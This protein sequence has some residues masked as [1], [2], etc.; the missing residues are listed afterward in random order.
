M[1]TRKPDPV[2]LMLMGKMEEATQ[3]YLD[4]YLEALESGDHFISSELI[5]Q[6]HFSVAGH[7]PGREPESVSEEVKRLVMTALSKGGIDVDKQV[8]IDDLAIA[9]K[10]LSYDRKQS[11]KS[12]GDGQREESAME[13]RL[14]A[15]P[16]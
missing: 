7:I 8:V 13:R 10:R 4:F 14:N 6:L 2:D 1:K 5:S 3:I 9:R 12:I 11:E 15:R 16:N